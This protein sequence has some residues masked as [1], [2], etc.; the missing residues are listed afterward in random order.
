MSSGR[1]CIACGAE[2]ALQA[3]VARFG[4]CP[5]CT[6]TNRPHSLTLARYA[7]VAGPA[8]SVG[9]HRDHDPIAA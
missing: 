8:W 2:T 7:R 6:E 1:I 4:R 5:D 9:N 3:P